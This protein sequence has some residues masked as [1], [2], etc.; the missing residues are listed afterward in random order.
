MVRLLPRRRRAEPA[1]ARGSL[2]RRLRHAN[3]R[4]LSRA[5]YL[6]ELRAQRRLL[7]LADRPTSDVEAAREAIRATHYR[8]QRQRRE[9]LAPGVDREQ[10]IRAFEADM[11][12][13]A[14]RRR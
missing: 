7:A 14:A 8:G 1:A 11:A 12:R 4:R 2:R 3:P 9:W 13:E 10:Q 6:A 5:E